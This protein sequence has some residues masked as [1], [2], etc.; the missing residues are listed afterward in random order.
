ML[1]PTFH[2][3]QTWIVFPLEWSLHCENPSIDDISI[4]DSL[5]TQRCDNQI[6]IHLSPLT[7]LTVKC[8]GLCDWLKDKYSLILL[9]RFRKCN[10]IN[11]LFEDCFLTYLPCKFFPHLPLLMKKLYHFVSTFA[12]K[13]WTSFWYLCKRH[14]W[15]VRFFAHW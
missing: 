4:F 11:S 9:L 12:Y 15:I 6:S 5:A 3:N 1:A 8:Q 13:F 14:I 2:A 10:P 7:Q